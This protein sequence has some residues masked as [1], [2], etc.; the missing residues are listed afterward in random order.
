MSIWPSIHPPSES[1]NSRKLPLRIVQ[2]YAFWAGQ[3]A[4]SPRSST[5]GAGTLIHHRIKIRL[6]ACLPPRTG[7][8]VRLQMQSGAPLKTRRLPKGETNT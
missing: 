5:P 6:G 1:F 8:M 7:A 3:C 2:P 4:R